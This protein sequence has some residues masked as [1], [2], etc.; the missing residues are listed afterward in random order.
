MTVYECSPFY[1]EFDLL[2]LK[3]SECKDW[4][5][6]FSVSESDYTFKYKHKGYLLSDE[7]ILH[8]KVNGKKEFSE[9]YFGLKRTYPFFGMKSSAWRNEG[10]QRN[11]ACENLILKDD[12]VVILSDID[13]IID[14][15]YFEELLDIVKKKKIITVKLH[16]TMFYMNLFSTNWHE[17]WPGSPEDYSYRVFLISGD[18][19]KKNKINSNVLRRLG[20]GGKLYNEVYC[21]PKI[22]GFHH[23]WLGDYQAVHNKMNAYAHDV[24]DHGSGIVGA[25]NENSIEQ[26]IKEKL[27]RKESIFNGHNLEVKSLESLPYLKSVEDDFELYK[28]YFIDV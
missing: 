20:E 3:V 28:N 16:F 22:A 4:V 7:G 25:A 11:R 24:K 19:F 13:E 26:F 21:Y 6:V 5:D 18:Y 8:Q 10:V 12:D 27:Q 9:E 1:N 23:S 17:V 2:N 15:R 14:S